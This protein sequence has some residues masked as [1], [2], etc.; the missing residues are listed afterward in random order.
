VSAARLAELD[1]V[2]QRPLSHRLMVSCY[3]SDA[4][5]ATVLGLELV[6]NADLLAHVGQLAAI[7]KAGVDS[8]DFPGF[9]DQENHPVDLVPGHAADPIATLSGGS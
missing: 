2:K 4:G 3:L 6:L 1:R 7:Q 5:T 9:A 8:P